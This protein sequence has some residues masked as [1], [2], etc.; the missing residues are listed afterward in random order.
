MVTDLEDDRHWL[1]E[2]TRH[3]PT[4]LNIYLEYADML[5][6]DDADLECRETGAIFQG[7]NTLVSSLTTLIGADD[8]A[9]NLAVFDFGSVDDQ[10]SSRAAAVT[11]HLSASLGSDRPIRFVS[12]TTLPRVNQTET[13]WRDGEELDIEHLGRRATDSVQPI[14][15]IDLIICTAGQDKEGREIILIGCPRLA[16]EILG[17]ERPR[18]FEVW[19]AALDE[20]ATDLES[21][22]FIVIRNPLPIIFIESG[23]RRGEGRTPYQRWYMATANNVLVQSGGSANIVWLPSYGHGAW[24]ELAATD[25]KNREIWRKLGF[26]VRDVGDFHPFAELGGALHCIAKVVHR[27]R[28]PSRIAPGKS[29]A[30]G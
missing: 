14:F 1:L 26:E 11:K 2:P 25:E 22:G 12:S 18:D 24:P 21:D 20:I 17:L 23:P 19:C 13:V 27:D 7:G 6:A 15:H 4:L 10:R 30:K 3:V 9:N 8:V 29:G 16:D 5:A 28:L